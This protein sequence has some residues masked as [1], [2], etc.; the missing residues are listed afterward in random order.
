MMKFKK[1]YEAN[2]HWNDCKLQL[3][4]SKLEWV[5]PKSKIKIKQPYSVSS[6]RILL[7]KILERIVGLS[8]HY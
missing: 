7:I 5:N 8:I 4:L 2:R 6:K 1:L 3:H